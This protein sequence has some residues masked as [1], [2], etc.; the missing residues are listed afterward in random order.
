M[1]FETI[2]P[3]EIW[4]DRAKRQRKEIKSTADLEASFR[5][6][7]EAGH[8]TGII[9]PIV[10]ERSGEL[11][12]GERRWT[13]AKAIGLTAV[14]I[15]YVDT[16]DEI[17]LQLLE[18]EENV[19][20][21][22]LDWKDECDAVARYHAL[23]MKADPEWNQPK[24]ADALGISVSAVS[25]RLAV[26]T[27]IQAGDKRVAAA[28]KFSTA[29]GIVSRQAERK[30][31]AVSDSITEV[32]LPEKATAAKKVPLLQANFN[33]WA[34]AYTGTKFNL[35][36]CDFPYG[37]NAD[38]HNQGQ[39]AA[40]GGYEDTFETYEKLLDT[41]DDFMSEGVADSAHLM[42]WFSMDYYQYTKDR[43][44]SMG[45]TIN[46]FPLIWVK[47]DNTG[48]LPDPQ[49]GPRRIYE[50]AFLGA[51]N[52][53]KIVSAVSNAKLWPGKDKSIH[54][55]EKP[56]GMLTHFLRMLVDDSTRFLDPTCGSANAVKVAQ[57][58]GAASVLGLEAID[59]FYER[60]KEAYF[61]DDLGV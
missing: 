21:V 18:L 15:Q 34:L 11:R 32:F 52:D 28:P 49:R 38:K 27:A 31:Q 17:G 46:P 56:K 48:I 57:D 41:L 51:R 61:D 40:Q 53:R 20:R 50:T 58:L 23:R 19:K 1:T 37:V 2:S 25:Q 13:A 12:A 5:S 55:S 45:W 44:T 39:A 24:T 33:E 42:F 9:N 16:L 35:L 14:P 43:L 22:D 54:M 6:L 4:V 36:H 3:D 47:D 7:I 60:A 59:E 26:N 10:I 30:A 8:P 29:R